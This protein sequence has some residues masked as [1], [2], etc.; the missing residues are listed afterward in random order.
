MPTARCETCK[1]P[2]RLAVTVCLI[3]QRDHRPRH[4]AAGEHRQNP[5][6]KGIGTSDPILTKVLPVSGPGINAIGAFA[7]QSPA[8]PSRELRIR[9]N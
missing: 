5:C 6:A 7:E 4:F 8:P 1:Q 9:D 3:Y 2:N